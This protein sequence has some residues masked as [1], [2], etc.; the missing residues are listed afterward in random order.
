MI[1]P[2]SKSR[3]QTHRVLLAATK[4]KTALAVR[5]ERLEKEVRALR[6]GRTPSEAPRQE[7]ARARRL[8]LDDLRKGRNIDTVEFAVRHSLLFNYVDE[9]LREFERKGWAERIDE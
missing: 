4:P 7:R 1:S 3:G 5:V 6:Q 8:I 2:E 9:C